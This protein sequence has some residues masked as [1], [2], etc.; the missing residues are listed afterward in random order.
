MRRGQFTVLVVD[1]E[2]ALRRVLRTSFRANGFM[3]EEAGSA[4]EALEVLREHVVDLALLNVNMPEVNGVELCRQLRDMGQQIGIVMITLRD[5]EE[6]IV[7]ALEAGADDC[8]TKPSRMREMM[9]RC[10]AMLRRI[11]SIHAPNQAVGR[12]RGYGRLLRKICV[13]ST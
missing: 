12:E 1:D 13:T 10:S 4:G 8:V 11:H 3:V 9:A 2:P 5:E 7:Q 6:D